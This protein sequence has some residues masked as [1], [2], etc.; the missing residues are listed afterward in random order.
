MGATLRLQ[1]L[2][3]HERLVVLHR[4]VVAPLVLVV[5]R[6]TAILDVVTDQ[7][8]KLLLADAD[9]VKERVPAQGMTCKTAP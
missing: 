4:L 7:S 6:Y 8:L 3:D 5:N 2:D 9:Q 1:E